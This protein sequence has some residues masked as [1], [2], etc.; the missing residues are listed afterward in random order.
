LSAIQYK[1]VEFSTQI[2]REHTLQALYDKNRGTQLYKETK[3]EIICQLGKGSGK[4]YLST[5]SV[6]RIAYLLMCLKDPAAYF[7]K[8]PG[9]Y[10]DIV[11]IA[12]NAPQAQNVFFE[13]LKTRI[14]RA[15]WF[16]GKADIKKSEIWFHK[17][18]RCFSGHSEV[19][20]WEGYNVL[21]AILDEIAGFDTEASGSSKTS[22]AIYNAY[23]QAVQSRFDE[24]GKVVL[25]SFPRHKQDFITKRYNE[26][27]AKKETVMVPERIV[28]DPDFPAEDGNVIEFEWEKD[29][30]IGYNEP[31]VFALRRPSW[32]VNPTKKVEDYKRAFMRNMTDSLGRFACMPPEAIDAFF[33]DRQAIE[34]AFVQAPV[35]VDELGRLEPWFQP[36]PTVEYY[37][38]VDLGLT[39]DRAAVAMAHVES[40]KRVKFGDFEETLPL[41]RL[42]LMRWWTPKPDQNV[43][44]NEIRDFILMVRRAGFRVKLVTFDK[45]Q[46]VSI[47]N[48]LMALGMAAEVLSVK[49]KHYDDLHTLF[50]DRRVRGYRVDLLI[51]E[52]LELRTDGKK[53]D[54]HSKSSKDISDAV[55][56]AIANALAYTAPTRSHLIEVHD[57]SHYKPTPAPTIA[58]PKAPT[59]SKPPADVAAFLERMRVV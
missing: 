51:E 9:D 18:I 39:N 55:T 45:W 53:V 28:I 10:I 54:H 21:V 24:T 42:D 33:K 4:D 52:L 50:A 34:E 59:G 46:S 15:K 31:R 22:E 57:I 27:I 25:L 6:A 19:E 23:S 16:V 11:N 47:M 2:Y 3:N 8:P 43:D 49:K 32:I 38:H 20:G 37:M 1:I 17:N 26:V 44:F 13:G 48:E 14:Q 41:V 56:G 29:N 35:P 36:D 7:G 30:I 5:I 40:W 58:L 12:I